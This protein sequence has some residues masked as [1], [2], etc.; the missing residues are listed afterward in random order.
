MRLKYN[1]IEQLI[2]KNYRTTWGKRKKR[3]EKGLKTKFRTLQHLEIREGG[4]SQKQTS[5]ESGGSK[6]AAY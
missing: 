5:G 1:F 6:R 3:I 4:S 2:L